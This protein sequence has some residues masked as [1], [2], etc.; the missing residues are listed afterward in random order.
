MIIHKD[1]QQKKKQLGLAGLPPALSWNFVLV[2]KDHTWA[3]LGEGGVKFAILGERI[4]YG[5]KK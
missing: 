3:I 2:V 1:K 5:A 4:V